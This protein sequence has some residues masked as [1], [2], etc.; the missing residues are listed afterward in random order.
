VYEH[1]WRFPLCWRISRSSFCLLEPL[2]LRGETSAININSLER[3]KPPDYTKIL[4]ALGSSQLVKSSFV[5]VPQL[6][7]VNNY[8][9]WAG[10][11]L[12]VME[13]AGVAKIL[14]G[15]WT[16]L[17][18]SDS[19][20]DSATNAQSWTINKWI[21]LN[22]TLT[23]DVRGQV[24]HIPTSHEKWM[25]LKE[26]FKPASSTSI[27]LHLIS[28]VNCTYNES[29]SFNTFIAKKHN[30]NHKLGELGGTMLPDNYIA[31][32]IRVRMTRS[33]LRKSSTSFDHTKRSRSSKACKHL[34]PI[35]LSLVITVANPP[36]NLLQNT[37]SN[38]ARSLAVP[39]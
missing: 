29:T 23:P 4:S 3:S 5:N 34:L 25:K 16:K 12:D 24:L 26:M 14:T 30:H 8:T 10:Q 39:S 9:I 11:L 2:C 38:L 31:I 28:I 1:P 13:L 37:I 7:G 33:R 27:T 22:L 32:L 21:S 35:L 20:A 15:N 18:V 19:D 6:S 17:A 36:T